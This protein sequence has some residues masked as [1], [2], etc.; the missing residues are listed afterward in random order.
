MVSTHSTNKIEGEIPRA[1][2]KLKHII[3]TKLQDTQTKVYKL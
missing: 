3:F 1:I 2:N